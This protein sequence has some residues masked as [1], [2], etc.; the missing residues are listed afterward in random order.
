MTSAENI[1]VSVWAKRR[2]T[3]VPKAR[4][5]CI[6]MF[7]LDRG[8]GQNNRN[9]WNRINSLL[10][11][12]VMTHCMPRGYAQH[13]MEQEAGS[14]IWK[15]GGA[16]SPYPHTR[17]SRDVRL[18]EPSSWNS[19]CSPRSI[20]TLSSIFLPLQPSTYNLSQLHL[21]RLWNINALHL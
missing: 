9:T 11:G 13:L 21:R 14:A 16:D 12:S 8:K 10:K 2:K 3:D 5:T 7:I 19:G 6:V 1:L 15:G 20:I 18:F 17:S 4:Y